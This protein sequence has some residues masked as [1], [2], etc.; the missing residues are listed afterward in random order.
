MPDP[1][2][3]KIPPG[4]VRVGSDAEVPGRWYDSQL[5]RWVGGVLRPVAGWER[6]SLTGATFASPIRKVH[7]WIDNT[8]VL[9]IGVLCE[10]HLYVIEGN[11]VIDISPTPAIEGPAGDIV[12]GGYGDDDYSFGDY[13][14][15]RPD[16]PTSRIIGPVWSLDNWQNDLVAMASTDG[17]LLRWVIG[18]P[19]AVAVTGAPIANRC[20]VITPER[21][22]MMFGVGG[23]LN[24][25]G[26]C[27][28]EDIT[29]WNFASITNTAGAYDL[30]PAEP[31]VAAISSAYGVLAFTANAA[32]IIRYSGLPS[33][34]TYDTLGRFA[35]PL[36]GECLVATADTVVWYS[37]DSFWQF[38]GQSI[39]PLESTLLDW[40]Q[41]NINF[42][43]SHYRMAGVYMGSQSEVWWFFPR[44]EETENALYV[45]WS[46]SEGWWAKGE[47]PR[48]CG[49]P[50][51]AATYPLLSDGSKLYYHEKGLYYYDAPI[52]PFAKSAAINLKAGGRMVTTIRQVVD[53]RAP[54]GDVL[55]SFTSAKTRIMNGEPADR[56]VGPSACSADGKLRLRITGRDLKLTVASALSGVQ[57]W[58]FGEMLLEM[59]V[60]GKR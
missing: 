35:S 55:F 9:R 28:Q 17:R 8:G 18:D 57:P 12:A 16:H 3:I 50:G 32:L 39:T 10:A 4:I 54:A 13:G 7:E 6:L 23:Q 45:V 37:F 25:F 60:R 41:Q 58:T 40:V 44:L 19:K 5:M 51:S 30:E 1:I 34:Y 49:Y 22:V 42:A 38:N 53:T 11:T 47:L 21:H 31:F 52:L 29:D 26:W 15:P 46:R 27:S 48:T 33:I 56:L 43:Y 36:S 14:T 59:Q 20:F 2:P 24:E